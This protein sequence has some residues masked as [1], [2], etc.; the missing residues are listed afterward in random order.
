MSLAAKKKKNSKFDSDIKKIKKLYE[1]YGI[2]TDEMD[3]EELERL[4]HQY[5]SSKQNLDQDLKNSEKFS[6]TFEDDDIIG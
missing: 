5:K 1:N 4:F 3:E 6:S 2:N